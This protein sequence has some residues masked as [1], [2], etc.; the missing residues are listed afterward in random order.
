MG[1]CTSCLEAPVSFFA[2]LFG[3]YVACHG[4]T[5]R[6][7]HTWTRSGWKHVFISW[8][9]CA[10]IQRLCHSVTAQNLC[11]T[12]SRPSHKSTR[13]SIHINGLMDL[14]GIIPKQIRQPRAPNLLVTAATG[15]AITVSGTVTAGELSVA[16]GHVGTHVVFP[17]SAAGGRVEFP[18][19]IDLGAVASA[20]T[21]PALSAP[22]PPILQPL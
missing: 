17:L 3:S 21:H 20:A 5:L 18:L 15:P 12:V 16:G 10:V 8:Q 19:F 22:R 4:K 1:Q 13:S 2:S 6:T 14:M 11:G 7:K 9:R